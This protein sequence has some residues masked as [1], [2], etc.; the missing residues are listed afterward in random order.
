MHTLPQPLPGVDDQ[1]IGVKATNSIIE[2]MCPGEKMRFDASAPRLTHARMA[3]N[4]R[5]V[6]VG[7]SYDLVGMRRSSKIIRAEF[8]G[9]HAPLVA[10]SVPSSNPAYAKE[11]GYLSY[12]SAQA[13]SVPTAEANVREP[14]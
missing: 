1:R 13:Q 6:I 14:G 8:A 12:A 9:V 7:L 2:A 5:H 11:A 4:R 10:A 3:R